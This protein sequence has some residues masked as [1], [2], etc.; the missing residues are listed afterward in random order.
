MGEKGLGKIKKKMAVYKSVGKKRS[1][2][3]LKKGKGKK[4]LF[5]FLDI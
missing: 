4:K 3:K 5:D 1:S 2:K